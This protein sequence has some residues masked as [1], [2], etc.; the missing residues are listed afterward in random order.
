MITE[1]ENKFLQSV[2]S[3]SKVY[4][5]EITIAL[6]RVLDSLNNI[7]AEELLYALE[8]C[9]ETGVGRAIREGE[10]FIASMDTETLE[11]CGVIKKPSGYG[12]NLNKLDLKD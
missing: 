8:K 7:S 4:N 6:E 12:V 11:K 2:L 10:E 9:P 3:A 1:A 5:P